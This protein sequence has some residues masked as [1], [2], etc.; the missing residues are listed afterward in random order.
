[1]VNI[2]LSGVNWLA[3]IAAGIV[4]WVVG[5]IWYAP[6]VFGKRWMEMMGVKM[7]PGKMPEGAGKAL[8][9]GIVLALVT[10]FF[11]ALFLAF[12]SARTWMDG[13]IGGILVWLG[14]VATHGATSIFFERRP[15][16]WYAI[17]QAEL[18]V[19]FILMGLILGAW[20]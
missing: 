11:L 3:V 7:E 10:A 13:A 9:G 6:P 5:A 8:G 18:A 12:M 17:T 2:D 20:H 15:V 14:F 19:S 16:A 4:A 1:M